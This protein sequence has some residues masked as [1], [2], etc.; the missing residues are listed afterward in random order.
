MSISNR[1]SRCAIN[2]K[3]RRA[4]DN[5]TLKIRRLARTES[6]TAHRGA[7]AYSAEESEVTR[8]LQFHAGDKRSEDCVALEEEDRHGEGAGVFKPDDTDIWNPHPNCTSYMTY[9]IDERWL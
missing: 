4:Y 3:N 8:W 9:I 2:P 6:L 1:E 7:I 5:E